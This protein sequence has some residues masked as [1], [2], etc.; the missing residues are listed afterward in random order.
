[1]STNDRIALMAAAIYAAR[2]KDIDL[3]Q[4]TT[5]SMIAAQAVKEAKMINRLIR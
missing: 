3:S 1:M 4:G 2:A 5:L